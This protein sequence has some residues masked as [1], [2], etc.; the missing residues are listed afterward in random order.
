MASGHYSHHKYSALTTQSLKWPCAGV[1][2]IQIH[3]ARANVPADFLHRNH[4]KSMALPSPSGDSTLY[5]YAPHIQFLPYSFQT[6]YQLLAAFVVSFVSVMAI[7]GTD[8]HLPIS[9]GT[10]GLVKDFP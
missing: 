7:V 10:P 3:A 8:G 6:R 2:L 5:L 1:F 4:C 9:L